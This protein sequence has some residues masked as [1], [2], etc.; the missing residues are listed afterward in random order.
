MK[1]KTVHLAYNSKTQQGKSKQD[2]EHPPSTAEKDKHM[3]T[4][5]LLSAKFLLFRITS[6]GN[7][8]AHSG[9][10][11]PTST[12]NQD[13]LC[14]ICPRA[15]PSR[16]FLIKKLFVGDSRP[17]QSNSKRQ[18]AQWPT[19]ILGHRKQLPGIGYI[20]TESPTKHDYW[21]EIFNFL[22]ALRFNTGNFPFF[23][24]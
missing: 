3:L 20:I 17:H 23:N 16:E 9:L 2:L 1:E 6:L 19:S 24:V 11:L 14:K 4:A 18:P 8:A 13:N 15:N 21:L 10:C 7:C 22:K 5:C 12:N